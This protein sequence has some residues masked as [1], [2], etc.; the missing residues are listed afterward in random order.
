VDLNPAAIASALLSVLLV[1]TNEKDSLKW[2]IQFK[3][4]CM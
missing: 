1:G 2:K 3:H 4:I